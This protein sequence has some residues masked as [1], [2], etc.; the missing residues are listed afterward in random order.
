M[1]YFPL[2]KHNYLYP[3][4]I[5]VT[6]IKIEVPRYGGI[7]MTEHV[8]DIIRGFGYLVYLGM[9]VVAVIVFALMIGGMILG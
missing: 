1:T 4:Q 9:F 6:T 3:L 7:D 2:A 8:F 5:P